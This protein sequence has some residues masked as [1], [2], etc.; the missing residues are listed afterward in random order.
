MSIELQAMDFSSIDLRTFIKLQN[1]VSNATRKRN[2][3]QFFSKIYIKI[4]SNFPLKITKQN[5]NKKKTIFVLKSHY[6]CAQSSG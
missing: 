3:T 2:S 1:C 5:V 6:W 4:E